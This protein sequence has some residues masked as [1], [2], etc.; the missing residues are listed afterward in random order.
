MMAADRIPVRDVA[1]D[2]VLFL[3]TGFG[4]GLFPV[5]PGTAGTVV[6]VGLYAAAV[7]WLPAW[8]YLV[9]LIL[10]IVGG[11]WLCEKAVQRLGVDDHPGIVW[12]EF[13]GYGI[14]MIPVVVGL[15]PESPL[16]AAIVGFVAF[17]FFDVI[18]P[19][20]VSAADRHVKGGAG[21]MLDDMMAA[22]YAAPVVAV[23]AVSGL[24][25]A[26]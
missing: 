4:S 22:V 21:V 8:A 6:A 7:T 15:A 10:L 5:A 23:V 14:T 11:F 24:L 26:F 9:A 18:K 3:A 25:P 12:D 13:A 19:W 16:A 20:P 2:P 17:R 1:R